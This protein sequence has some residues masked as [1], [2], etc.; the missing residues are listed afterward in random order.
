MKD[1]EGFLTPEEVDILYNK[2]SSERDKLLIR[3]LWKSGRRIG[4]ILKVRV[5]DIDFEARNILYSIEKKKV[6]DLKK[7][8]PIDDVTLSLI[9]AWVEKNNFQPEQYLFESSQKQTGPITRQRAFQI[10]RSIG[11]EANIEHVG[12]KKIHPH[13]FRHSFAVNISKNLKSPA[14]LRKLQMFLEHSNL[15]VTEVYLQFSNEDIR[16]LIN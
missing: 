16:E 1:V 4:E 10:I 8:K 6:K 12:N 11:K 14:D 13:H 9:K 5:K 3:M 2:A 15:N 7:W